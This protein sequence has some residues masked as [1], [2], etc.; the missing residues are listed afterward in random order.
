MIATRY[1]QEDVWQA[2]LEMYQ[3]LI[4]EDAS[5]NK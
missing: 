4:K 2:T 1:K 3:S 5:A